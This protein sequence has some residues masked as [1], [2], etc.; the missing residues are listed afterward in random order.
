MAILCDGKQFYFFKFVD[1]RHKNARPQLF[2]GK[3][4]NG[5]QIETIDTTELQPSVNPLASVRQVRRTCDSLYYI[6]LHGYQSGLEAYWNRSLERAKSEGEARG[7]TPG[8]HNA[9]VLAR[10]ALVLGTYTTKVNSQNPC[11]LRMRHNDFWPKGD[12]CYFPKLLVVD[13]N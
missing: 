7:S 12:I 2:L 9:T 3:S 8:W 10:K 11:N 13:P 4:T 1:R 5:D 6:F